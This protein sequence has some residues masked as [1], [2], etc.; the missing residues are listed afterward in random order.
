MLV[1]DDNVDAAHMLSLLLDAMGHETMVEHT[2]KRA[3][4][5]ARKEMPEVCLLDIGLPDL[6]GNDLAKQLRA[7][8]ETARSVLIAITGYGQEHD[9]KRTAE[10]GFD[11]HLVKPVNIEDLLRIMSGLR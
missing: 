3:L 9:R 11:H 4:E 2:A 6:D 8:P 5:R 10:S 1:V 7:R